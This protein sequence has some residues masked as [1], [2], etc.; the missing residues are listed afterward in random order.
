MQE[1]KGFGEKTQEKILAGIDL[2]DHGRPAAVLGRGRQNR[3][4]SFA[5]HLQSAKAFEQIE[6]AGSY[7]RGKETV[8]DLDMLVD[9]R[10]RRPQ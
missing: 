6:V 3:R 4:R 2:A 7:R 8:G 1:L 10:R 9:C 5:A